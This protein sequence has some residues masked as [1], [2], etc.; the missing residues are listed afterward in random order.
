MSQA[1][2]SVSSMEVCLESLIDQPIEFD[3][4]A[5]ELTRVDDLSSIDWSNHKEP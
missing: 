1:G 2:Y 5:A 3:N 4:A